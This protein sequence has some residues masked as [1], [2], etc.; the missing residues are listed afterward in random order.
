VN[1]L[2]QIISASGV[3][4]GLI[5]NSDGTVGISGTTTNADSVPT[6]SNLNNS[7]WSLEYDSNGNLGSVYQ[8][9]GIGSYVNNITWVGYSGTLPGIGSR[10]TNIS[11]WSIV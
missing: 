11:E 2:E 7:S 1:K 10:V 5:V 8:M 9:I 4:H 6:D 3:Q